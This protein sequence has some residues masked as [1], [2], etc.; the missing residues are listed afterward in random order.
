MSFFIG[1]QVHPAT[2]WGKYGTELAL[3]LV[4]R[5]RSAIALSVAHPE[6][7]PALVRQR[8]AR[9]ADW[10]TLSQSV[11]DIEVETAL[12]ALGNGAK[13]SDVPEG[14]HPKRTAAAIFSEDTA[15]DPEQ[16]AA[17]NTF[18][19]VVAGSSWNAERLTRAGVQNV[20]TV[21]QGVS[22]AD[23]HP[24]PRDPAFAGRF[25]IFSGGKLEF[26]K[27][28]DLVVAAFR[29]FRLRHPEALLVTAWQNVWP[30]TME[31]I[32][33]AGHVSGLPKVAGSICQITSW[34][35]TN[36]IPRTATIDLGLIANASMPNIVRACDVALFPNRAEGGTNLVAMECIA[37]GV[38]TI[39]AM[40]TGQKDLKDWA[41][42]PLIDQGPV[43]TGCALYRE[44]DEW[45]ESSVEEILEALEYAYRERTAARAEAERNGRDFG[46]AFSW[47]EVAIPKLL[48]VVEERPRLEV[49]R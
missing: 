46:E 33:L 14:V 34:L 24:A 17:L 6:Q 18:P 30:A 27:G 36:G 48:E 10:T 1:W 37:A 3:G 49:V 25:A 16:V 9:V 38:P 39:V 22:P 31:G 43:P 35:E 23:W 15:L 5:K 44:T 47:Q 8:L 19:V 11:K 4:A 40:N 29:K 12:V 21:I 32:H 2:G 13:G 28:Q 45:G 7:A 41:T 42:Y 20:A 26:R